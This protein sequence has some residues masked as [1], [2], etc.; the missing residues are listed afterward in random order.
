[1]ESIRIIK[2]HLRRLEEDFSISYGTTYTQDSEIEE[3]ARK[4]AIAYCAEYLGWSY[5][6]GQ[7]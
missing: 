4:K 6:H 5:N 3:F 2:I 1:M 7:P